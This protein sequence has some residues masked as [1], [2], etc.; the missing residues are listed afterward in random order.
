MCSVFTLSYYMC[1]AQ[2]E[3]LICV[4]NESTRP[5]RAKIV[6]IIHGW[7]IPFGRYKPKVMAHMGV[8]DNRHYYDD[9]M[10]LT[11]RWKF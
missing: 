11:R 8:Y 4:L 7:G 3:S 9:V 6:G 1:R 5:S 2:N 10:F